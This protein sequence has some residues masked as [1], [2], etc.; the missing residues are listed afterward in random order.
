MKIFKG[1]KSKL[2][3]LV[4]TMTVLLLAAVV[5]SSV[6]QFDRYVEEDVADNLESIGR[7]LRKELE[8]TRNLLLEQT[9]AMS[10]KE[11]LR[12]ALKKKD[13]DALLKVF[14]D[15]D[16]P[17]KADF[18]TVVGPDSKVVV[19]SSDPKKFDDP[20]GETRSV[21]IAMTEKKDGVYYE[22]TEG[23]PLAIRAAAPILDID[24]TLLGV[25]ST[26][27]R[28]D[29]DEFVDHIQK[30]FDVE[31]TAL[32]GKTRV[33]TTLKGEDGKRVVGTELKDE[34]IIKRVYE[35]RKDY[36]GEATI[37][38]KK[39]IVY[40]LPIITKWGEMMG[41]MFVG[42][43][44]ERQSSI[45]QHNIQTSLLISGVGL[46][47]FVV[48]LLVIISNIVGPIRKM[49]AAANILAGG[50]LDID[51]DVHTGDELEKLANDFKEIAA[52]VKEKTEVALT[53]AK[54]DL[55]AWVP[56]KSPDDTLGKALVGMRYGFYDSI[57]DLRDLATG[58]ARESDQLTQANVQL[59]ANTTESAAQ[60][61]E[62]SNSV[63]HLNTQTKEN[64]NNSRNAES[65]AGK[66]HHDTTEGQERMNRMVESMNGITKSS[67]EIKKIIRVIDDIAFQ[68]NLLALNAAVEAAR[69]GAHGKGF[70]V[71]AEE[72][73][74]L[75]ARSA[76]A[77]KETA[78][79]I[80][81]SIRQVAAGSHVATET[82][83]SLNAIA[84]QV[85]QVNELI[86][87]I[88]AESEQQTQ[89]LG[90]VNAAV[91]DLSTAADAN[92]NAVNSS[93]DAVTRVSETSQKLEEII[94]H[95]KMNEGGR[96]TPPKGA[97]QGLLMP[98]KTD[99]RAVPEGV[100]VQ[101]F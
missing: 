42:M 97:A 56:L 98:S 11:T 63:D 71:V 70:A 73:R 92:S 21:H 39:Y 100:K 47:V 33:A 74:T 36:E 28:L 27:F 30:E 44:I 61:K 66:A 81:E 6:Y 32:Y 40:Y 65:L 89:G 64:A 101:E 13:R 96:V 83:E 19:R 20:F 16:T 8:M 10:E 53:I 86:S 35:E 72:V 75:A 34:K 5:G 69:A 68:T 95:F 51:L 29:S 57:K 50:G 55:R 67:E 58:I 59:V 46:L 82:S 84:G 3:A 93:A 37:L 9:R 87:K 31:C 76:K 41:S 85:S 17:K 78:D 99:F 49:S 1:I 38:G 79:L 2:L 52:S 48:I 77:A 88:S 54:G 60:L 23:I 91:A 80:E 18:F 12:A 14:K 90:N 7:D 94:H 4:I 43:P 24:G 25:L 45:I 62:V 26:G 15:Y 22:H